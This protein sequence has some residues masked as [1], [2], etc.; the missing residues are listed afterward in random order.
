MAGAKRLNPGG[1]DIFTILKIFAENKMHKTNSNN[2]A[3]ILC[4][5]RPLLEAIEAGKEIDKIYIQKDLQGQLFKELWETL[6]T[7]KLPFAVVPKSRLDKFTRNNHQGVI[8]HLSA[9]TSVDL[10][11]VVQATFE[12]G[13]DPLIVILDRV[14][15]VRN[16]GAIARSAEAAGAHAIVATTKNSASVN[17][18]AMK[19]SAG[20]LN[21]L[22]LCKESNLNETITWLQMSGIRVI[23]C[24]E[25]TTR[26]SFE[27]DLSG[28]LAIIMGSEDKGIAPE[29][30][31]ASDLVVKLPMLGKVG[32]LNVSVAAGAVLYEVVRQRSLKTI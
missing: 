26:L 17:L 5:I 21:H 22:P 4:G 8:A 27:S 16:F 2:E 10:Q 1:K 24:S 7:K 31:K 25:K 13:E 9:V 19:A 20:A 18:D 6:K 14:S 11:E 32:S 12:K 28:P 15:D 3:E 29:R 30:I 23:A